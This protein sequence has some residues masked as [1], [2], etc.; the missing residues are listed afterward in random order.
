LTTR[1]DS[2]TASIVSIVICTRRIS[3][4]LEEE[5]D[6]RSRELEFLIV[7]DFLTKLKKNPV[8]V[9]INQQI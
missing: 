9:I 3:R 7:E 6:E 2:R 1:D 8:I 5:F 4:Y